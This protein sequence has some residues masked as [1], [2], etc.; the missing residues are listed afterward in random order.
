VWEDG[1]FEE[2]DQLPDAVEVTS[3]RDEHA[4]TPIPTF[5]ARVMGNDETSV[6]A[7]AIAALS[8]QSTTEPGELLFPVT[9]SEW[10][11]EQGPPDIPD[12]RCNDEIAFSP[13]NDP[14]SCG[15]WTSWDLNSN[16]PNMRDILKE[17]YESPAMQTDETRISTTG[18]DL[19]ALFPHMM[20]MFQR[21]GCASTADVLPENR[22]QLADT[23]GGCIEWWE[24][25]DYYEAD[26]LATYDVIVGEDEQS[27]PKAPLTPWAP[28]GTPEFYNEPNPP[29]KD[30]PT[31]PRFYHLWET[32]VP[33]YSYEDAGAA[34][35]ANPS[36]FV[37]WL[38]V[39]FA[40][41]R[42]TDVWGPPD[43]TIKGQVLCDR[44]S[45][46][47]TRGGGGDFGIKGTIPGLVR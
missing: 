30:D 20:N 2:T 43:N 34:E 45:E 41:V 14:A 11:F 21:N 9:L 19:A 1:T 33:V 42:I 25:R 15:G 47:D 10:F 29:Y 31:A 26:D 12:W 27:R 5:F 46:Y 13:T 39:G 28:Y 44:Y 6:S 17:D 4:N 37:D 16:T 8:G 36:A 22:R 35:C 24:A 18:G 23:D 7:T 40:P 32:S 38:V 3:R